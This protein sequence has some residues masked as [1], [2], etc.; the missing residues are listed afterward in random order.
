M[1]ASSTM[2]LVI[3]GVIATVVAFG[4]AW[5]VTTLSHMLKR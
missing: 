2:A 5:M 1:V 4:A 3:G